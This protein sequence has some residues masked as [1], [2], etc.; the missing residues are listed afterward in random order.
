MCPYL[1]TFDICIYVYM[2]SLTLWHERS[3]KQPIDVMYLLIHVYV[4]ICAYIHIH[5]YYILEIIAPLGAVL[6]GTN[7]MCINICVYM[8]KKLPYGM[9]DHLN[10]PLMSYIY[11]L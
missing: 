10:N 2:Q 11:T 1:Y 8:C 7:G 6:Y 5:I 3:L 9:R 4:F